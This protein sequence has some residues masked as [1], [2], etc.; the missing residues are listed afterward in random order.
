MEDNNA[1]ACEIEMGRRDISSI[2]A[3]MS[4]SG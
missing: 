3:L 1:Q 2:D 4:I